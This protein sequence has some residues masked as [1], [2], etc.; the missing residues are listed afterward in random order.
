MLTSSDEGEKIGDDWDLLLDDLDFRDIPDINGVDVPQFMCKIGKNS[1]N[2]RKQL[3]KYQLIYSDIGPSM[4]TGTTLTQ[5]LAEREA[6]A[7]SIYERYSIL[8]EERPVIETMDYS[9]KYKKILD[10]ICVD[11]RK[12][13]GMN[14][15]DEEAIIKIKGE[16][17][18][19]KDDPGA[20]V[21]PIRLEGKINLNALVDTSSDIN[22]IPYRIYKEL[23]REEVQNVKKGIS[24][25]NHSKAEPMGLLSNVLC[26]VG[27]TTRG[28]HGSV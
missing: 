8:E 14:K 2:T 6:L 5:E 13:D 19:E 3:E 24:M 20:F 9:D 12:L 7:I 28:V 15:E 25:L 26:Q 16:S 1:R 4:S 27:V 21:I 22:V 18:I 17:L 10:E 23:G 11:K